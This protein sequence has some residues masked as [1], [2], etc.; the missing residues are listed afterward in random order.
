MSHLRL[1]TVTSQVWEEQEKQEKDFASSTRII[2][3]FTVLLIIIVIY[4][5]RY[6]CWPFVFYYSTVLLFS[7]H[8]LLELLNIIKP[9]TQNQS[10]SRHHPDTAAETST[11]TNTNTEHHTDLKAGPFAMLYQAVQQQQSRPILIHLRNN[12]KLLAQT[13][14]AYDRHMN[15]LLQDVKEMWT[16]TSKGG[17]GRTKGQ[18]IHKDRY[19]AKMF[20][21]GDSV[22]L[23]VDALSASA[24]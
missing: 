6:C 19:I 10:M 23:I 22:I 20:V 2:L 3:H 12:H 13:L 24:D 14:K 1:S 9:H 21:R 15:L 7:Y 8:T 17:T 5:Q 11:I 4:F 16:E 18:V